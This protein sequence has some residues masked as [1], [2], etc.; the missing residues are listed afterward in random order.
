MSGTKIPKFLEGEK[1]PEGY[2][3]MPDPYKNP[4]KSPVNIRLLAK[5]AKK[6]QKKLTELTKD[7]VAQFA[8]K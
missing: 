8:V 4:P 3:K 2:Y 6:A 5:Y 7:E 1:L